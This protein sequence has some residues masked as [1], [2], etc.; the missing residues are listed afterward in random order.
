MLGE[1][2]K[3]TDVALLSDIT[4]PQGKAF[5]WIQEDDPEQLSV[6]DVGLFQ[7]YALA[8]MYYSLQE[9]GPWTTCG[10]EDNTHQNPILCT[11]RKAIF[12]ADSSGEEVVV[13][14][15]IPDEGKW[16]SAENECVWFG[17]YCESDGSVVILEISE[18]TYYDFEF[19]QASGKILVLTHVLLHCF[20]HCFV[21]FCAS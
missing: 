11:G 4:T 7:R 15:D 14:E 1:I 3:L 10:K 17:V 19:S 6:K 2:G 18:L 16:L 21:L 8:T 9:K 5:K 13:Y 12:F 20:F